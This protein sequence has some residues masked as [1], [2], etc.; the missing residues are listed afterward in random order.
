MV[1]QQ[2]WA[3]PAWRQDHVSDSAHVLMYG[4][5]DSLATTHMRSEEHCTCAMLKCLVSCLVLNG[6]SL[7][8]GIAA[9][10]GRPTQSALQHREGEGAEQP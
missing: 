6:W 2:G 1:L 9:R 8:H 4:R 7:A 10:L 5:Q 3:S